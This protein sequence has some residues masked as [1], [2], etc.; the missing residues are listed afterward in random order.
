MLSLGI[1]LLVA[2]SFFPLSA[3][4]IF[5]LHFLASIHTTWYVWFSYLSDE[6]VLE[7]DSDDEYL[8]LMPLNC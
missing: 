2:I 1:E 4:R 7:L 3:L 8:Y 6:N 5:P